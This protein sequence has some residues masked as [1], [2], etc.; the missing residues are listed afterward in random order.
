MEKYITSQDGIAIHCKV[1]GSKPTAIVFVHGWL[2]NADWWDNQTQYFGDK[3]T[4]V[5]MD[6][7]GHGKSG[8]GRINWSSAQYA[9]D[10]KAVIDELATEEIVLV[11]HSMSGPFTLEASL[12]SKKV[13]LL[14]IVDTLKN[15]DQLID[16]TKANEFLFTP[17]K[18]DFN[19]AVHNLLPKYLF[20]QSTPVAIREQL[21]REFLNNDAEFAVQ[22]IEPLYKM[23]IQKIAKQV[24]LPVRAIN[25][26]FTPTDI[27]SVRK[28]IKDFDY[29]VITG[30]GHYPML[31]K[32]E[33]FNRLLHQILKKTGYSR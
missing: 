8:K 5:Q 3:Y 13:K 33:E 26:D 20:A 4:V 11:G 32:P 29:E 1:S 9:S 22:S 16:Y 18:K 6:L 19:N 28:Y 31:E 23:D 10:I 30:A 27:A 17:Y 25:S 2:G 12:L 21:Q 15:M 14:V 7:P 24:T